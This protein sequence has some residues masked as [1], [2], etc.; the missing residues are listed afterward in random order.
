MDVEAIRAMLKEEADLLTITIKELSDPFAF[1]VPSVGRLN[2]WTWVG[3]FKSMGNEFCNVSL[4]VHFNIFNKMNLKMK[5][6][7]KWKRNLKIWNQLLK[8]SLGNNENP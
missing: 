6:I 1:I 5:L 2:N 3:F 7:H 4:N 8:L